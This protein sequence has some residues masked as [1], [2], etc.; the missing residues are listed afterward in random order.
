M[1]GCSGSSTTIAVG[2]SST[3]LP[4]YI[5]A[6]RF[7]TVRSTGRSWV[8]KMTPD[9]ILFS[10]I[11]S[12]ISIKI[13]CEVTSSAEVGSSATSSRGLSRVLM[14]VTVRCFMPPDSWWG[15]ASRTRA[16]RPNVV[17]RS[18]ARSSA[19]SLEI[20]LSCDRITS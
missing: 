18:R 19:S 1:Y 13:F 5:T 3:I 11:S 15:Y 8:T 12:S 2:P 17:M 20:L 7:A 14:I 10:S 4:W 16:G 6:I 9:M